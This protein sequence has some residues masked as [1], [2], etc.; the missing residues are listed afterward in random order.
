MQT[1]FSQLIAKK[2]LF[3]QMIFRFLDSTTTTSSSLIELFHVY[4]NCSYPGRGT[5]VTKELNAGPTHRS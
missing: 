3:I 4:I 2:V 1:S 5:V